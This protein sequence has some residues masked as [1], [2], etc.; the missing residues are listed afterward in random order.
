MSLTRDFTEFRKKSIYEQFIVN[1]T[2][3]CHILKKFPNIE[4][5]T[6]D[7]EYDIRHL[8]ELLDL[9]D[10]EEHPPFKFYIDPLKARYDDLIKELES[11]R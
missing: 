8:L 6:L 2:G 10:W 7:E 5:K 4:G 3:V 9:G 1:L 11:M